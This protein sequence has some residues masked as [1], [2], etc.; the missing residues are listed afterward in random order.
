[1][2][3]FRKIIDGEIPSQKIYEDEYCIAILDINPTKKGHSLVISKEDKGLIEELSPE[4]LQGMIL[5]VKK[6]SQKMRDALKADDTNVLINNG[7]CAGQEISHVHIHV[8]P[9]FKNDGKFDILNKEKYEAGEIEKMA[10][11]L[12]IK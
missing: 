11:L 3:I 7:P 12:S 4:V 9:R 10:G 2:D 6:I 1:M 8:I 5:A